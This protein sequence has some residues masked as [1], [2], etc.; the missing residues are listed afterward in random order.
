MMTKATRLILACVAVA[1]AA[2][3]ASPPDWL[4][5]PAASAPRPTGTSLWILT[6]HIRAWQ[7]EPESVNYRYRFAMM[8]LTAAGVKRCVFGIPYVAGTSTVVSAKAWAMSPD[9]KKCREFGGA[10]FVVAS[11]VVNNFTWDQTKNIV[12]GAQKFLQPGWIVAWEIEIRSD[13]SAFDIGWS[14]RELWPTRSAEIEIVPPKNGA[15]KWRAFSD[16]VPAPLSLGANGGLRWAA[17]DLPGVGERVP[18]SIERNTMQ[19]RA[20]ILPNPQGQKTWADLVALARKE[21]EPKAALT[22]ALADRAR[23]L[24]GTGGLW[25]KILPV[26]RFVQKDVSYLQVTIDSD[27]MAGY[28]P[29][30]AADVCESR[31]GDCKDKAVLLCTM[32][33]S[34]G[35]ESYVTLV[36]YGARTVSRPDWPSAAFNHAIVAIA[37]TEAPPEGAPVVRSAGK[38][39]VLFDPTDDYVPFGIL[40]ERDRGG[41]GL[42]LAPACDAAVAIPLPSVDFPTIERTVSMGMEGDGSASVE[43]SE[44]RMGL[45]AADAQNSDETEPLLDRTAA[46][47]KRIEQKLPLVSDMTWKSSPGTG[48]KTWERQVS[49]KA[50]FV[51]RRSNGLMYVPAD[52]FSMVPVLEPWTDSD[53]GFV[54][55]AT[56][57]AKKTVSISVPAGWQVESLPGDWTLQSGSTT[58][59]LRYVNA[60]GKVRGEMSIVTPG[61]V[62]NRE[63]YGEY[64]KLLHAMLVAEH[65]PV[66]LRRIRPPAA[67][68]SA[69]ASLPPDA[70]TAHAGS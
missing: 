28:R 7:H 42:V 32:L 57:N 62:L 8:P 44:T 15:V 45:L 17:N 22:P 12:L 3:A 64:R 26:C 65:R 55:I 11:P 52:V 59:S 34:L 33:R 50:Q 70:P 6:N 69:P 53:A 13:S 1:C 23:S 5:L 68:P 38:D 49:F 56:A 43:I 58:S 10:E 24:A 37:C 54:T 36:N 30:A 66:V 29:H 2:R 61:G 25:E 19:L 27:S 20:Y 67:A 63:Q 18:G 60:E 51:G 35:V 46:L 16:D 47:E 39:F 41:L 4:S 48:G 40:P 21:M 9:G 14:P 31:F